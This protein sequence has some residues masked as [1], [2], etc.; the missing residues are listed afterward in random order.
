MELPQT[1]STDTDTSPGPHDCSGSCRSCATVG[2]CPDRLVCR[3]LRVT[4]EAVITAIV[5]LGLRTVHEVRQATEAGTGCNGCHREIAA[6]L[7]DYA[8]SS[9]SPV[10]CSA[11]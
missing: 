7:T 1:L 4:E 10:I 6:Y 2:S 8:S 9:S 3:C 5:T 11:K